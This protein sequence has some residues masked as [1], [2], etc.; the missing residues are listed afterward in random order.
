MFLGTGLSFRTSDQRL[1]ISAAWLGSPVAYLE[2]I[3]VEEG[4]QGEI[5]QIV[6]A[7]ILSPPVD[8]L[9]FVYC[10]IYVYDWK[11]QYSQ[12]GASGRRQLV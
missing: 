6:S 8:I 5:G 1:Q 2:T 7:Q 9:F 3:L 11:G 4:F 10:V 12:Q